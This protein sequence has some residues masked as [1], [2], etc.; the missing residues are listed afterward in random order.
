MHISGTQRP[1]I[2]NL[3]QAKK[4]KTKKVKLKFTFHPKENELCDKDKNNEISPTTKLLRETPEGLQFHT[5][6]KGRINR[7]IP[8]M[9]L[10]LPHIDGKSV[11]NKWCKVTTFFQNPVSFNEKGKWDRVEIKV[12]KKRI[13]FNIQ[14][15]KNP[16]SHKPQ[17]SQVNLM[18]NSS[19]G[20]FARILNPR[21]TERAVKVVA[22]KVDVNCTFIVP[23]NSDPQ[24]VA[25]NPEN[26]STIPL[27]SQTISFITSPADLLTPIAIGLTMIQ[28][29]SP[30]HRK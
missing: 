1:N 3:D 23:K 30:F 5:I 2:N 25:I 6:C 21:V 27:P 24:A 13:V 22:E 7:T 15:V 20:M 14:K 12:R 26:Q 19:N 9:F 18:A 28:K 4:P 11:M 16:E 29:L 17:I 8:R 10:Q